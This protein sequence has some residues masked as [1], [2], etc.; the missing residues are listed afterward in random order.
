MNLESVIPSEIS[1]KEKNKPILMHMWNLEKWYRQTYLQS[2]NRHRHRE[3][4]CG[5]GGERGGEEGGMN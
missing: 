3:W 5:H 1:Q 4:T 2:R